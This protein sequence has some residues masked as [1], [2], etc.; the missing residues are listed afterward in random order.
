MTKATE[1]IYM[2]SISVD[3]I[4]NGFIGRSIGRAWL[5]GTLKAISISY[6]AGDDLFLV[7][8]GG[9]QSY[10]CLGSAIVEGQS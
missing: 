5:L 4:H 6:Q 3:I 2:N 9:S 8:G 10:H 1:C 7:F